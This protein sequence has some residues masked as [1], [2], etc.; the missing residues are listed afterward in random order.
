MLYFQVPA[1]RFHPSCGSG[2]TGRRASLRSLWP[3]GRGGS[4]PLF[5]TNLRSHVRRRLPAISRS[6]GAGCLYLPRA[7][8]GKPSA[9]LPPEVM[10]IGLRILPMRWSFEVRQR[11]N[12]WRL[13]SRRSRRVNKMHRVA[14]TP[15][16]SRMRTRS[17]QS[18]P[19]AVAAPRVRPKSHAGEAPV[20]EWVYVQ[21]DPAEA[22]P[23]S[24]LFHQE[25][26]ARRRGRVRDSA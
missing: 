25:A 3:Q 5:R 2:G 20:T 17:N 15:A 23:A 6:A 24:L 16:S 14:A 18:A 13:S 7:S 26:P 1:S 8:A 4:N 9:P 22:G 10:S 11:V 19:H 12:E 21:K